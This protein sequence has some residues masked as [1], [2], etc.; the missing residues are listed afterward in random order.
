MIN[1]K[2]F[3]FKKKHSLQGQSKLQGGQP[4]YIGSAKIKTYK[5]EV[6]STDQPKH[7][8]R[9]MDEKLFWRNL[10]QLSAVQTWGQAAW[11]AMNGAVSHRL[12]LHLTRI[13]KDKKRK[14]TAM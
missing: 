1:S 4:G 10:L 2:L 3:Y 7:K 8:L 13:C 5:G 6:Q 11:K 14:R 12:S 9:P